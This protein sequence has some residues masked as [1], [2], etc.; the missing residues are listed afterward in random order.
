[1]KKRA[2]LF[3]TSM[4][5]MFGISINADAT[6]SLSDMGS[7][8]GTKAPVRDDV[9]DNHE[10]SKA[11]YTGSGSVNEA[12][13]QWNITVQSPTGVISSK[14]NG[15]KIWCNYPQNTG[16][17]VNSQLIDA[18][19][20]QGNI[21]QYMDVNGIYQD[22]QGWWRYSSSG[23]L[24]TQIDLDG[25][26]GSGSSGSGAVPATPPFWERWT[27]ENS[28]CG[29]VL[30]SG[31]V[32]GTYRRFAETDCLSSNVVDVGISH[33]F[34][35][36]GDAESL[37]NNPQSYDR[38]FNYPYAISVRCT[39]TGTYV[40]IIRTDHYYESRDQ[41]KECKYST[42]SFGG[43]RNEVATLN[44]D[45]DILYPSYV[46]RR[47]L[48]LTT[49]SAWNGTVN[50]VDRHGYPLSFPSSL[51]GTVDAEVTKNNMDAG[52]MLSP[53]ANNNPVS[54]T[55]NF[56][57][58]NWYGVSGYNLDGMR[59]L[60]GWNGKHY[61][62]VAFVN[63][64]YGADI[65]MGRYNINGVRNVNS[66]TKWGDVSGVDHVES[67]AETVSSGG[68]VGS[69]EFYLRSIMENADGDH[70]QL[71]ENGNNVWWTL[72]RMD[73]DNLEGLDFHAHWGSTSGVSVDVTNQE[74][75]KV[76]IYSYFKQ[77]VLYGQFDVK[78]AA[79]R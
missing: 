15:D 2:L 70:Y 66:L 50:I 53:L 56:P 45:A 36:P 3:L 59:G 16:S 67:M 31:N 52:E 35:I 6:H 41:D 28:S 4:V 72:L 77:P 8:A 21:N 10:K 13:D 76:V 57:G 54:F 48:D 7:T 47:P 44:W 19:V 20:S 75:T 5:L 38:D 74:Y 61:Q 1:M 30:R 12:G 23:K 49:Q 78:N 64:Y 37:L 42:Y 55:L 58:N 43:S 79:G 69:S 18:G 60:A 14:E 46:E 22:T 25:M 68:G 71:G 62:Y 26:G 34:S 24:V 40:E 29:W 11:Q 65:N 9:T 32:S 33:Y 17:D 39:V 51:S 73:V 27:T 63:L